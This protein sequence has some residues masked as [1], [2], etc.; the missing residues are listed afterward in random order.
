MD[1]IAKINVVFMVYAV[2]LAAGMFI[3]L[4]LFL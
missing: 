1:L 2:L 4:V 3:L